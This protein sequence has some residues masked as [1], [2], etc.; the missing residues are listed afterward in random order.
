MLLDELAQYELLRR[1]TIECFRHGRWSSDDKSA[2]QYPS[3]S[4]A[5]Q[6]LDRLQRL[7]HSALRTL[8]AFRRTRL[9]VVVSGPNEPRLEAGPQAGANSDSSPQEGMT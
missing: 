7:F 5:V 2:R 4:E 3:R 9:P 1:G 6:S 8:L